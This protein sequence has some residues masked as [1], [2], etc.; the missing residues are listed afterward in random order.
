MRYLE[1]YIIEFSQYSCKIGHNEAN[2]GIVYDKLPYSIIFISMKKYI[3]WLEKVDII[4]ALGAEYL[5]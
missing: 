3:V 4:D 1:N 5:I 2:L